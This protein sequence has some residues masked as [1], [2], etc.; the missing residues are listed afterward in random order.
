MEANIK[1]CVEYFDSEKLDSLNQ[2]L[3][4]GHDLCDASEK[5]QQGLKAKLKMTFSLFKDFQKITL[6]NLEQA[7]KNMT[8]KQK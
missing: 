1:M 2:V 3:I 4:Y 6:Q 5:N 7:Q 8:A